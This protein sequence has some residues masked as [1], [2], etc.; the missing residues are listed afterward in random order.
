MSSAGRNRRQ[1]I[2]KH[3][4]GFWATG[5]MMKRWKQQSSSKCPRCAEEVEDARHVWKCNGDG[6]QSTWDISIRKLRSWMSAQK[7]QPNL[8]DVV[9][10]RLTAWRLGS[11]PTVSVLPFLGLSEAV[12]LQDRVGWQAFLEG[13][14]VRQWAEV[15]Q[16]YYEWIK[17]KSPAKGGSQL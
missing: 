14:P 11:N 9:C 16:C 15:Q 5:K 6:V 10:D 8:A 12:Q 1:W 17:S 13:L 2:V 4:S 7:T 3:S